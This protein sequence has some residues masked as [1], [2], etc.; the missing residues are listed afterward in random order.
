MSTNDN[1][2]IS[3]H[4]NPHAINSP[5]TPNTLTAMTATTFQTQL[6]NLQANLLNFAMTLTAIVHCTP[7]RA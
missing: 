2:N 1:T 7:S 5:I 6:M 3:H 4:N